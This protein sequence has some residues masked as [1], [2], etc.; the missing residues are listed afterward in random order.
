MAV[1]PRDAGLDIDPV[2][3][4]DVAGAALVLFWALLPYLALTLRA[5]DLVERLLRALGFPRLVYA[6]HFDNWRGPPVDAAVTADLQS[7]I[8][9]VRRCSPATR[10][11]IPRHF[12]RMTIE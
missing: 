3:A 1:A 8:G 12:Q 9:E 2:L 4:A 6:T 7:F 5:E 11:V 10:V